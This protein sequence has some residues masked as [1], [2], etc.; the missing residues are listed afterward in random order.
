MGR[1]VTVLGI[2]ALL[3]FIGYAVWVTVLGGT[4]PILSYPGE[5]R[6]MVTQ[7]LKI[8]DVE[9]T[10]GQKEE[11][12]K[13]NSEVM[14]RRFYALTD[15]VAEKD[16]RRPSYR[17]LGEIVNEIEY[18]SFQENSRDLIAARMRTV[19]QIGDEIK[20]ILETNLDSAD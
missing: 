17:K 9:R 4:L 10:I 12:R 20:S 18:A 1:F 7:A 8:A 2:L 5:V 19:I 15:A 6:S 3:A 14:R 13:A 16:R 11:E